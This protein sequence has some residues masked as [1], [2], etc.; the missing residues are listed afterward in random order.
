MGLAVPPL[1]R[2]AFGPGIVKPETVVAWHRA[3]LR[4]FWT[5]EFNGYARGDLCKHLVAK[6]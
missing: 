1:E 6:H 2:L 5:L 4:R 3:G